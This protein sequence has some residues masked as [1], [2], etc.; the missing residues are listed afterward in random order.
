MSV[1]ARAVLICLA[2]IAGVVLI[3]IGSHLQGAW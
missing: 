2:V 3:A 1:E